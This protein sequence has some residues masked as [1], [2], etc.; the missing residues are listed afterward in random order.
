MAQIKAAVSSKAG[1]LVKAALLA[2][3]A[4][5]LGDSPTFADPIRYNGSSGNDAASAVFAMREATL[6]VMPANTA[7][8][9]NSDPGVYRAVLRPSG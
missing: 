5:L 3:L 2:A 8:T 6:A 1:S 9:P 4:C 7:T